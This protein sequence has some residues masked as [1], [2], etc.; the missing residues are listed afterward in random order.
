MSRIILHVGT[1]KTGTTTVQDSMALNRER[2]AARG[3]VFP[4]AGPNAGQHALVTRWIDLPERY[5]GRRPALETWRTLAAR[6]AGGDAAVF[7][8]SEE[9]SRNHPTRVDMRELAGL[10][11]DFDRRTVVCVLRNQLAYLQSIYLQ[12]TRRSRGPTV[13]AFVNKALRTHHANGVMLDYGALYDHLLSGFGADEI[14]FLSFEAAV[15]DPGGLL[16][17][18]LAGVGLPG[19]ADGL[20]P[21]TS[22]SNVSPEPLASWAANQIATPRVADRG[23]TAQALA[24]LRETF[25]AEV[26]STI[27]SRPEVARIAAHFGPLNA[28]F[29][30]RY[31]EVNP[32]FALAPL[33]LSPDLL[34]R[35]QLTAPQFWIRFGRRVYSQTSG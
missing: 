21:L 35:G 3:L 23:L 11:A 30:A 19:I 34:Y 27:Y 32:D 33:A 16:G 26:R 13:E 1:H 22:A 6:H 7:V 5:R 10:V 14:V 15:R 4:V 28:A 17:H 31:R 18:L 2:L 12:V 9:F 29:E 24:A 8:S 25:G 20:A